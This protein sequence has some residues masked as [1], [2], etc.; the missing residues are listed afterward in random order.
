MPY[1][2]AFG[3]GAAKLIFDNIKSARIG[4]CAGCSMLKGS[5]GQS[6]PCRY[7]TRG[8]LNSTR[9]KTDEEFWCAL[10]AKMNG[11]ALSIGKADELYFIAVFNGTN[12][13]IKGIDFVNGERYEVAR[14]GKGNNG[15][16]W[17]AFRPEGKK[18]GWVKIPYTSLDSFHE[19][20]S[21]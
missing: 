4:R 1:T 14:I 18:N 8:D 5:G 6:S 10:D 2:F 12:E 9:F 7:C 3:Q 19:N 16:E 17:F 20:W 13:T 11:R 15:W 21:M